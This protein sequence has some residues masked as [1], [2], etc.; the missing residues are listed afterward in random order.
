MKTKVA[1][2]IASSALFG[3]FYPS[4]ILRRVS[5][6]LERPLSIQTRVG[7]FTYSDKAGEHFLEVATGINPKVLFQQAVVMANKMQMR[8]KF[9]YE[10]VPVVARPFV[11]R[12]DDMLEKWRKDKVQIVL[13]E[14]GQIHYS[15]I[16]GGMILL[17]K[18]GKEA[19]VQPTMMEF[20]DA[21]MD[22]VLV[23]SGGMTQGHSIFHGRVQFYELAK[24]S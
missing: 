23:H 14:G 18:N 15:P 2:K 16:G 20:I 11:S 7:E 17:N 21:K 24:K 10:G 6:R 1:R 5:Q 3:V 4:H 13:S 12:P 19:T 8:I 9:V 22:G